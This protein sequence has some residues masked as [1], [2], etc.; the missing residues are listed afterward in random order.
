[1]SADRRPGDRDDRR[2]VALPWR[3][4]P[5][6][7]D[8]RR[9]EVDL[10]DTGR[11]PRRHVVAPGRRR[12]RTPSHG[13]MS[14]P[15]RATTSSYGRFSRTKSWTNTG[16]HRQLSCHD[17]PPEGHPRTRVVRPRIVC[18]H[19]IPALPTCIPGVTEA[20][21]ANASCRRAGSADGPLVP[22]RG[23]SVGSTMAACAGCSSWLD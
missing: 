16:T 23:H 17:R 9:L 2:T 6:R 1:M 7:D 3:T 14:A 12:R 13:S 18:G 11:D 21:A 10:V 15:N 5:H 19:S 22:G 20:R 4:Q 8:R